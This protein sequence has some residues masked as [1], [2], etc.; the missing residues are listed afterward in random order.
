MNPVTE[1]RFIPIILVVMML[2]AAA[3]SEA[4]TIIFHDLGDAVAFEQLP[5]TPGGPFH[6]NVFVGSCSANAQ[7]EDC[8]LDVGP[9][10]AVS[11]SVS[12]DLKDFLV[13]ELDSAALSDELGF[14][15]FGGASYLLFFHSAEDS[16]TITCIGLCTAE[17]GGI[18]TAL[19]IHWMDLAG[20][21]TRT[22]TVEFQ[23]GDTEVPEPAFLGIVL[24][25]L[26][27]VGLIL[28]QRWTPS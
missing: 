1:A 25:G 9:A 10:D 13:G 20:G 18:Q 12:S 6:D 28:R 27:M 17:T 26:G 24:P 23:S 11:N 7:G 19:N 22:D 16:T 5:D 15:T 21:L 2:A 14:E 4:D 8:F 3:P